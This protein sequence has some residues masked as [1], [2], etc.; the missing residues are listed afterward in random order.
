VSGAEWNRLLAAGDDAGAIAVVAS[1]PDRGKVAY[2]L[3]TAY[4]A[5]R[6]RVNT[7]CREWTPDEV[8]S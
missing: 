8:A 7:A 4:R 2:H 1:K 6:T 5:V 3:L